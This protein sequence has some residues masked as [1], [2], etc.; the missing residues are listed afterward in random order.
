MSTLLGQ[1][2]VGKST[3]IED[4][5]LTVGLESSAMGLESPARKVR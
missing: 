4:E 5:S 1:P 2:N 3:L